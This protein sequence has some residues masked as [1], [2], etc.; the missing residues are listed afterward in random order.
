MNLPVLETRLTSRYA[1]ALIEPVH[2]AWSLVVAIFPALWQLLCNDQLR[3]LR[4]LL[5]LQVT[6]NLA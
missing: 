2:C 6:T 1:Y 3:V 5:V 4:D